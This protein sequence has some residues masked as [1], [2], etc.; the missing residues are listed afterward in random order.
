MTNVGYATLQIIPS[1]KGFTKTLEG[2]V[3]PQMPG[4]GRKA[5]KEMGG[6]MSAGLLGVAGK[7]LPVIGAALAGAGVASFLTDATSKASD[8]NETISKTGAIFGQDAMPGLTKFADAA[9]KNMGLSKGAALDALSTFGI[10]A[11]GAGLTGQKAVTFSTQLAGLSGDLASFYNASTED[12]N[13]ALGAALRG[14]MEPARR[15]GIMLDDM[16]LRQ[17]AL[18]M[19]LVKTTKD[20]LTPQQKALAA[21][22]LILQQTKVAQ[23][24]FQRTSGGLANQQR[25]LGAT[26]ENLTTKIG[27]YFL[28]IA[29]KVVGFLNA[30]LVPAFESV[31]GWVTGT[32]VPAIQSLAKSFMENVWPAIVTIAGI[33]AENLQPAIQAL[34]EFWTNTL[35]PGFQRALP[36]LANLGKWIGAVVAVLLVLVSWIAGKVI[37]V[38]TFLLKIVI[39]VVLSIAEKVAGAAAWIVDHFQEIVDFVRSIP[40]KV[41]AA[42]GNLG[43]TLYNAGR[44]LIQGL[45][46]G[47]GSLLSKIGSF[48]LDKLPSWIVGPFKSAL[49]IASPSKVFRTMGRQTM[50]GYALG[51]MDHA[52]LVDRAI[53]GAIPSPTLDG[54]N[55]GG[56]T[57]LSA[58]IGSSVARLYLDGRQVAE[59]VFTHGGREYA[60]GRA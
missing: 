13:L 35:V 60:Y 5:G 1:A 58:S 3:G 59:A 42:V 28:P 34:G 23:G 24:D 57:P 54:S 12:V 17:Q 22:A 47:A 7:A 30:N 14:E 53:N 2:E 27:A 46:N 45:L 38:W 20:A 36:I 32:L 31:S 18:K 6:G 55:A 39:G 4:V 29:L 50:E 16:S 33:V 26:W 25:I 21:Q 8:L 11:K 41:K 15:F 9:A 40:S 52:G 44:D 56:G 49:G 37:P 48:F 43:S 51:V 19:G 10:M